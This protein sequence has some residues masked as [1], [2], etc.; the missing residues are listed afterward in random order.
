VLLLV[1]QVRARF[2]GANL[3]GGGRRRQAK[4]LSS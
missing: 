3:G 1:P 4:P 2:L